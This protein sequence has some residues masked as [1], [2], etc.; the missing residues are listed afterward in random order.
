LPRNT[1]GRTVTR[2]DVRRRKYRWP[3][4]M[5]LGQSCPELSEVVSALPK[6]SPGIRDTLRTLLAAAVRV[7]PSVNGHLG[8]I[9][10]DSRLGPVRHHGREI[11]RATRPQNDRGDVNAGFPDARWGTTMGAIALLDHRST[12]AGMAQPDSDMTILDHRKDLMTQTYAGERR[13]QAG[14]A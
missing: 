12:I 8:G 1:R 9:G 10:C 14:V 11:A 2:D 3:A 7:G 13:V 4:A 5:S 6:L